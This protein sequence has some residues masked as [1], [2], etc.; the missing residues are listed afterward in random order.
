MGQLGKYCQSVK[1]SEDRKKDLEDYGLKKEWKDNANY[2]MIKSEV[3]VEEAQIENLEVSTQA[4][5]KV[6]S[7][8]DEDEIICIESDEERSEDELGSFS[9]SESALS[10]V[11]EN[12]GSDVN[13][14]KNNVTS[15]S[16]MDE[17][18]D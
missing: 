13:G 6:K 1:I 8:V 7:E 5:D 10:A 17:T 14:T 2:D 3:E 9:D 15:Y 4:V 12:E 16:T 11:P 18:V